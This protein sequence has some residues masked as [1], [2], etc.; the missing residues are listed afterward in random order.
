MSYWEVYWGSAGILFIVLVLRV[1][2]SK[3]KVEVKLIP[4]AAGFLIVAFPVAAALH[5][6]I[7]LGM[8]IMSCKS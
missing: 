4:Y 5:F 6:L 3:K 8:N 7:K 2:K 1:L